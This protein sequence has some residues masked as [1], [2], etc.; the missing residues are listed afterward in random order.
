MNPTFKSIRPLEATFFVVY[1]HFFFILVSPSSLI[2]K[3][4]KNVSIVSVAGSNGV[5]T[6]D[7]DMYSRQERRG[8][9]RFFFKE[10]NIMQIEFTFQSP[11][12]PCYRKTSWL[13]SHGT[14]P[15]RSNRRRCSPGRSYQHS[16][17]NAGLWGRQ[18]SWLKLT[19]EQ[20]GMDKYVTTEDI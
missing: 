8:Y 4:V 3:T 15:V 6:I 11:T 5:K 20:T 10:S 2:K 7:E 18:L 14:V 19:P 16:S 1:L 9:N 17:R 13:P 12:P